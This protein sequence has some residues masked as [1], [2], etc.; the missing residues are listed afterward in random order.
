MGSNAL[1]GNPAPYGGSTDAEGL[2]CFLDGEQ[3]CLPFRAHRRIVGPDGPSG[4]LHQTLSCCITSPDTGRTEECMAIATTARKADEH[5]GQPVRHPENTVL[6]HLERMV[7]TGWVHWTTI[8]PERLTQLTIHDDEGFQGR[9]SVLLQWELSEK[10]SYKDRRRV[11]D[12]FKQLN[13]R[14]DTVK[15]L[16][17]KVEA[18]PYRDRWWLIRQLIRDMEPMPF[19]DAMDLALILTSKDRDKDMTA[20]EDSYAQIEQSR[21]LHVI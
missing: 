17:G 9:R 15:D 4:L 2:R 3:V 11:E 20:P 16:L 8:D 10:F 14:R 19:Q 13:E 7:S 1:S 6:F 18:L 5:Q 12:L 21:R